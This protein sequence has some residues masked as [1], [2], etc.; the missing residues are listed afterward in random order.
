[1]SRIEATDFPTNIDY[2]LLQLHQESDPELQHLLTANTGLVL[3]KLKYAANN[4][5]I[6]CDTST[7]NIRP[8]IPVNFR[9][10]VFKA[11]HNLAHPGQ[12]QS[13]KLV[14][15]KYVWPSM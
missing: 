13:S 10:A 3:K 6:Y 14:A 9:K 11:V 1:M 12:R 7:N 4:T 5:F 2:D 8:Y 15:S